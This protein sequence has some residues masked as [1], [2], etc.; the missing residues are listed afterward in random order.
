MKK[1]KGFTIIEAMIVMLIV[2]SLLLIVSSYMRETLDTSLFVN[3]K[4]I[5]NSNIS[6]FK[7]E[8]LKDIKSAEEIIVSDNKLSFISSTEYIVFEFD[9]ETQRLFRANEKGNE[10]MI[11][12]V[13]QV[14]FTP[15]NAN[16]V[17]VSIEVDNF[18]DI[19]EV[20]K[21]GDIN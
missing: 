2:P 13:E 16:G 10:I 12:N 6:L 9:E 19:I 11:N 17:S 1:H 15:I 21:Q 7:T 20:Y 5:A 4:I 8:L 14:E 3:S 18:T